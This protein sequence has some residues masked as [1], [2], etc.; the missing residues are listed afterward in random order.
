MYFFARK[1]ICKYQFISGVN[2]LTPVVIK[3]QN[4]DSTQ[5]GTV[6]HKC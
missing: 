5:V 4:E 6:F 3:C 1:Y 2:V